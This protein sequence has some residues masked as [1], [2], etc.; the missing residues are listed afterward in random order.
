MAA[1]LSALATIWEEQDALANCRKANGLDL[2]NII[3]ETEVVKKEARKNLFAKLTASGGNRRKRALVEITCELLHTLGSTTADVLTSSQL[4]GLAKD[5]FTDCATM[6]GKLKTFDQSQWSSLANLAVKH[7]GNVDSWDRNKINDLRGIVSGLSV[8]NIKKLQLTT[9]DVAS[10]I[11][12]HGN[13]DDAAKLTAAFNEWLK[14]SKSN[15]LT[16]ITGNELRLIGELVCGASTDQITQIPQN[17]YMTA[18]KEVGAAR[19]CIGQQWTHYAQKALA[20]YGADTSS[21]TLDKTKL[22]GNV[23]GG[24]PKDNIKQMTRAQIQQIT[25]ATITKIPNINFCGFTAEQFAWFSVN[26]AS[27]VTMGQLAGLEKD[28][29]DAL[30]E[31]MAEVNDYYYY[32]DSDDDEG[33]K[34]GNSSSGNH[35]NLMLIL[36][37]MV[38]GLVTIGYLG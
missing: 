23:I 6:L 3:T 29:S 13:W 19:T 16:T 22:I 37:V 36:A 35:G 15:D 10:A 38:T 20:G 14:D 21:W 27:S 12:N 9:I 25:P 18:V 7:W 30:K 5:E 34:G 33:N 31:V 24:L 4:S 28:Q 8:D 26:Q 2:K 1:E 17:A 32:Y 11:G